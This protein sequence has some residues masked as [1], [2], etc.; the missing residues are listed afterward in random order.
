VRKRR[1][2]TV[3][4]PAGV[5]TGTRLRLNREGE[6]GARGGP[7]GD[8][9][10]VMRVRPHPKFKRQGSELLVDVPISFPKAA[11]GG[12]TRIELLDGEEVEVAIAAGT[13]SGTVQRIKGKG[14]TKLGSVYK[15]DL[16]VT[17]NVETP[18]RL[19]AKEKEAIKEL[20]ELMGETVEADKG[21][22]GKVRDALK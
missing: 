13:Q 11:L 8:L 6:A 7:P 16:L 19:S 18:R 15:G 12:K 2:V 4:V 22:L 21:F 5:D 10:V 9:F 17:L 3:K 14:I 1:K 20:A